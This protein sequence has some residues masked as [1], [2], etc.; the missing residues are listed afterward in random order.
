MNQFDPDLLRKAAEAMRAERTGHT[1][2]SGF[3][4]ARILNDVRAGR[5]KRNRWWRI[6][7]PVG[8]ILAG[9]TAWASASG[10]WPE[11]WVSVSTLL[12][13]PVTDNGASERSLATAKSHATPK[14]R[15]PGARDSAS[16]S[17]VAVPTEP[18]A[19]PEATALLEPTSAVATR[20]EATRP[21]KL[22]PAL[23]AKHDPRN[24]TRPRHSNV[25]PSP[26]TPPTA[27]AADVPLPPA[28]EAEIQAFRKADDLYRRVGDLRAAVSAYQQYVRSYPAGR[29]V[30]EA[31]YNS[32]L[33]LLKLGRAME[34]RTLL[35]P[36]AEGAYGSYRQGAARKLL[37]ALDE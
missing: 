26:A 11:V 31:K 8:I 12:N 3:T 15:L 29:F 36:F 37:D 21:P 23:Q 4:R 28:L 13:L 16:E 24:S 14:P 6:G 7:F 9:T 1:A 25:A 30:P 27:P 19:T 22:E 35:T 32:A 20:A 17:A 5:K 33:A 2:G 10:K 18:T 34:A